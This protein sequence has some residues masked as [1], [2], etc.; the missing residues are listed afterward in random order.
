MHWWA[1]VV[2]GA[3]LLGS[4]LAF[5]EAQ[6]YL[7]FLGAAALVVGLLDFSGVPLPWW[8]QWVVFALLSVSSMVLFRAKLYHLLR[9]EIPTMKSGPVGDAVVVPIDLEPG[10]IC[11]LDY[12]GSTWEAR[13]DSEQ[14]LVAGSEVRILRVDGLTLKLSN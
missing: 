10:A 2:I 3:I 1:W 11:R 13:N 8:G 7:V 4:E 14:T 5:V 6:F 12:R 9:K